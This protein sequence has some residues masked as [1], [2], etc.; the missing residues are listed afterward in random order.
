MGHSFT[1]ENATDT[2]SVREGIS[3]GP[4]SPPGPSPTALLHTLA[5]RGKLDLFYQTRPTALLSPSHSRHSPGGF[6]PLSF[7]PFPL[8]PPFTPNPPSVPHSSGCPDF[9]PGPLESHLRGSRGKQGPGQGP[10]GADHAPCRFPRPAP[11][12][13]LPATRTM[14]RRAWRPCALVA[15]HSYSPPWLPMAPATVSVLL[16]LDRPMLSAPGGARQLIWAGG[17]ASARQV[18]VKFPPGRTPPGGEAANSA[19]TGR[20]AKDRSCRSPS[21]PGQALTKC[22]SARRNEHAP[23]TRGQGSGLP[24]E[25]PPPTIGL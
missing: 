8:P 25:P 19:T 23:Q 21:E 1:P 4:S 6:L 3:V 13:H 5:V 2:R 12:C 7:S 16:L 9:C 20:S 17:Q 18:N 22:P 14:M 15:A 11:S 24:S 10:L